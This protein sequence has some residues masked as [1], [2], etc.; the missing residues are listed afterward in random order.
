MIRFVAPIALGALLLFLV[1]PMMAKAILPTHGGA[2]AVW[3]ACL[4]FYQVGL[5]AGYLYAYLLLRLPPTAQALLHGLL[6]IASLFFLPIGA[7][8]N[9]PQT[10]PESDILIGL[11]RTIGL[12]YLLL[13]S[14]TPLLQAWRGRQFDDPRIYRWFA[15][16]NFGSL[17]GL[18][19]YPFVIEP[20]ANLSQQ[21]AGWSIGYLAYAAFV[22][23]TTAAT[24]LSSRSPSKITVADPPTQA[25]GAGQGDSVDRRSWFW[26][27]ATLC[28]ALTTC[29]TTLLSAS[30][31]QMSQSG[32]VVP[33]LWV[34]PLTLYL[35]S[36]V[37]CFQWAAV[38]KPTPWIRLF[39]GSSYVACALL[40][41]GMLLPI[42]WQIA[43]YALVVFTASMACHS[44]LQAIRPSTDRLA[45]YYLLIALGGAIGGA[46][47]GLV[48]PRI[49]SEFWEFHLGIASTAALLTACEL[50]RLA[51]RLRRERF[52][53]NVLAPANLLAVAFIVL[54]LYLHFDAI[55]SQPVI[56]RR[57]D[58]FGVVSVIDDPKS[59]RRL[60]LHGKTQHG[61][62][63]LHGKPTAE[64]TLYFTPESGVAKAIAWRRGERDR[65][66]RLGVIGLGTGSLL[67][68]ADPGDRVDFYEISPAVDALARDH[69][70]YLADHRGEVSVEI[71]DGRQLLADSLRKTGSKAFDILVIDAFSG[72]ALP[73]HL[74]TLEAVELYRAH[75]A[76]GGLLA[77][78]ITNRYL[79]LAPILN[80]AAQH[81]GFRALIVESSPPATNANDEFK[82]NVRWAIL[83]PHNTGDA[84]LPEWAGA[85]PSSFKSLAPWTDSFG[86]LWSALR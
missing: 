29:S 19:A 62:Q 27:R 79:D 8:S 5:L 66:L 67:V 58:F 39:L 55:R 74:L 36:F 41:A 45:L 68:H 25:I 11:C 83:V 73:M 81:T 56:E 30:T 70:S 12:P 63:P 1:Q 65:P 26:S 20:F 49:F 59:D 13:S 4:V 35:A 24:W 32:V 54:L 47:T 64:Q 17:L 71:G 80:A 42:P 22:V 44:Q 33:F 15:I 51:P 18:L 85:S 77:F 57:R 82:S 75:L 31:T 3:T 2:A 61:A 48:A 72:D 38:A 50:V 76:E 60:M 78:Q 84:D 16:S 28:V 14:T 43:G 86:S 69:F 10:A 46:L 52:A 9:H 40:F 21:Q 37:I 34:L 53:R 6:L 23:F 7:P